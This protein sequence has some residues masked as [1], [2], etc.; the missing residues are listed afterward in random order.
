MSLYQRMQSPGFQSNAKN[1]G[2]PLLQQRQMGSGQKGVQMSVFPARQQLMY[3]SPWR[4]KKNFTPNSSL[5]YG[6]RPS[7]RD[8]PWTPE[9]LE[10]QREFTRNQRK[11]HDSFVEKYGENYRTNPDFMRDHPLTGLA[12]SEM[13]MYDGSEPPPP[14]E[15]DPSKWNT[16]L[17][18]SQQVPGSTG[19]AGAMLPRHPRLRPTGP[20]HLRRPAAKPYAGGY[21]KA[22]KYPQSNSYS[23]YTRRIRN[24]LRPLGY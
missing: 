22:S 7:F 21:Q 10:E 15:V 1:I 23:N 3:P 6:R 9:Q 16:P 12:A 24:R 19:L 4:P 17:S 8:S 20:P 11:L 2:S 5:F 14:R 13:S 18:A